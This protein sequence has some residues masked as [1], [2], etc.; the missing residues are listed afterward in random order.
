MTAADLKFNT[1]EKPPRS[2]GGV[3]RIVAAVVGVLAL[4]A[5]A[6]AGGYLLRDLRGGEK[7]TPKPTPEVMTAAEVQQALTADGF[8]CGPAYDKPV[9]IDLCYR[10]SAE[11]IESVG[12]Q[13]LAGGRTS[14]L[15]VRVEAVHPSKQ[16]VKP[17][18]LEVFGAVLGKA[19]PK[20]DAEEA[21]TWLSGNLPEDYEKSEYLTHEA[22]AARL[23]LLP[24]LKKSA[25]LWIRLTGGS[26]HGVGEQALP[27]ATA[28]SMDKHY[29]SAGF[30]CRASKGGSSCEKKG[31]AGTVGVAYAVKDSK[32][33]AVRVTV[34]PSG[35]LGTAAATAKAE[36]VALFELLLTGKELGDAKQWLEAGFDDKVHHAVLSGMEVRV[37]PV[38]EPDARYEV[39]VRPPSW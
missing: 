29:K 9:A 21:T 20:A 33:T 19:L 11:F 10:D 38:R 24:R 22:G 1:G 27:T 32:I 5:G 34:T 12:F 25:L 36:A 8:E 30:T 37:A 7:P 2:G 28:E 14:W 15:K 16:P 3:W 4:L 26:Y 23:Q 13:K 6:G 17:R 31:D 18:A 39:D 35:E